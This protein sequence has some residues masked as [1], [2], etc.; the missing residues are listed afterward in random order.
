[1]VLLLGNDAK[2]TIC[3]DNENK[4]NGQIISIVTTS[5]SLLIESLIQQSCM[6]F[7]DDLEHRN[8]L[9]LGNVIKLLK[10]IYNKHLLL[11]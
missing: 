6:L 10:K 2:S 5:T 4:N 1:M 9:Y 7:E 11:K 8:K 3:L